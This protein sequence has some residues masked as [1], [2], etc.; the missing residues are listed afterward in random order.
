MTQAEFHLIFEDQVKKCSDTLHNKTKEYTG[1]DQEPVIRP[2]RRSDR[3]PLEIKR[4]I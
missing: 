1:R 2:C 3:H 4:K